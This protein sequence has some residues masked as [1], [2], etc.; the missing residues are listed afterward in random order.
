MYQ[1]R[2]MCTLIL[3]LYAQNMLD[4]Q[5]EQVKLHLAEMKITIKTF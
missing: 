5:S 2:H 1:K 3:V 4:R